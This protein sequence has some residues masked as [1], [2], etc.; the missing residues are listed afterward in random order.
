MSVGR[1]W[2]TVRHLRPSQLA[3]LMGRGRRGG[4]PDVSPPP[5][6]RTPRRAWQLRGWRPISLVGP[7][8]LRVLGVEDDLDGA[9]GWASPARERLWQYTAHYFDDLTATDAIARRGWHEGLIARWVARETPGRGD[10]WDPYPISMRVTNWVCRHLADPLLTST[11]HHSLAVQVRWL[12]D[13]L[14]WHLLGNHLWANAKALVVA[15]TAC[16]GAEADRWR[17]LGTTV[18]RDALATQILDDGGHEERS[19]MYHALL[20]EDVLDLLQVDDVF[21]GVMEAGLREALHRVAAPMLRWLTVMSHPD[22]AVTFFNDAALGV[23]APVPVL[24]AEAARLGVQAASAPRPIEHLDASGYVRLTVPRA[25]VWCDVAPVGPDHQPGHAHADT[26]SFELS[27]DEARVL[28]NG[29]TSTYAVGAQR[30]HERATR[31]HNTV[32]VDGENSSEVWAAFR[33]GRRARVHDVATGIDGDRVWCRGSHDGYRRFRRPIVHQRTWHLAVDRLT[34]TDVVAGPWR[35][36]RTGVLWHPDV[37]RDVF[38][39]TW[40][41]ADD[42]QEEPAVWAPGFGVRRPTRRSSCAVG[43]AGLALEVAWA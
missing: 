26:L 14:E 21:P 36:A 38:T 18:L 20:L 28:V 3:A 33:V 11:A 35:V 23:A 32:E 40:S 27:V 30:A 24:A 5:P 7:T 31:S 2:R 29:G 4:S 13:H 1:Y 10:G 12:A 42:V 25:V 41:P 39:T 17:R 22:G 16:E 9:D 19:P 34:V 8:R 6:W 43:R 37:D 15:G